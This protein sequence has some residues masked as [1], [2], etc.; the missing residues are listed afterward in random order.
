MSG[1]YLCKDL[2][3][4]DGGGDLIEGVVLA[5]DYT[6]IPYKIAVSDYRLIPKHWTQGEGDSI[7]CIHVIQVHVSVM[8]NTLQA[9][10]TQAL[11][12]RCWD[13]LLL[14]KHVRS[15]YTYRV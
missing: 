9:T 8:R 13:S 7:T 1:N 6:V 15:R 14:I 11:A 3:G 2:G 10:E 4:K 5:E 12:Y